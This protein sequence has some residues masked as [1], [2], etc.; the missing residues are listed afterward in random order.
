MAKRNRDEELAIVSTFD[1]QPSIADWAR[2]QDKDDQIRLKETA[3]HFVDIG[4]ALQ[5]FFQGKADPMANTPT[6]RRQLVRSHLDYYISFY[7]MAQRCWPYIER[8]AQKTEAGEKFPT[9]PG[10]V[11]MLAVQ[12]DYEHMKE[13]ALRTFGVSV[14]ESKKLLKEAPKPS[15]IKPSTYVHDIKERESQG[16][17]LVEFCALAVD[18]GT[19][20]NSDARQLYTAFR[21]EQRRHLKVV[22]KLLTGVKGTKRRKK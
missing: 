18:R 17:M 12:L 3:Q 13:A 21:N 8:A 2:C 9:E 14:K 16:A 20:R 6:T 10:D 19:K 11:L 1:I 15:S 5:A 22:R 7:R 4:E